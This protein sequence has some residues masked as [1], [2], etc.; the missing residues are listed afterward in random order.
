MDRMSMARACVRAMVAACSALLAGPAIAGTFYQYSDVSSIEGTTVRA[1]WL[2]LAGSVTSIDFDAFSPNTSIA[3]TEFLAQGI[4]LSGTSTSATDTETPLIM[5]PGFARCLTGLIAG[6][7]RVVDT[8]GTSESGVVTLTFATPVSAVG[9]RFAQDGQGAE[10]RTMRIFDSGNNPIGVSGT[11]E[12]DNDNTSSAFHGWIGGPGETAARVVISDLDTS[13]ALASDGMCV[14]AIEFTP[15]AVVTK[16]A[17]T[18]VPVGGPASLALL[19]LT[20]LAL[21]MVGW[22]SRRR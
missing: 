4:Q 8:S 21:V 9:L 17:P 1:N 15:T 6:G 14:S 10:S 3:G 2:A 22:R 5:Y 11:L 7:L 20:I 13:G 19:T 12:D 16:F 18:P